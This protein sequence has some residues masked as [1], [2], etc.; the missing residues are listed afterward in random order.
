[1]PKGLLPGD[2]WGNVD[3]YSVRKTKMVLV[4]HEK[5]VPPPDQSGNSSGDHSADDS[6]DEYLAMMG[7][8]E[9]SRKTSPRSKCVRFGMP[10]LVVLPEQHLNGGEA[11]D[12]AVKQVR[13]V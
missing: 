5:T 2:A 7:Y 10:Q 6:E 8:A 12:K 3:N 9:P 1:M 11:A 4:V 13:G